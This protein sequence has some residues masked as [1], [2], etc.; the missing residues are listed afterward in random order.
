MTSYSHE[1][2]RDLISGSLPWH[3]TKRIMSAYKDDDRFFKVVAVFQER[4]TWTERILLPIGEH[5]FIV[6]KGRARVTK[7]E[8]G[9]E[10]GRRRGREGN[11]GRVSHRL[12]VDVSIARIGSHPAKDEP[13]PVG[14][15]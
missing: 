11:E 5:L 8:C 14:R 13:P 3:Q 9:H 15:F 4:V 1:I 10:F 6:Q 7:C 12:R 2:I